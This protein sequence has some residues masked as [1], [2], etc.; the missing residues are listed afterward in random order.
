M[1]E[2]SERELHY[3]NNKILQTI[4]SISCETL[5]GCSTKKFL[6]LKKNEIDYSVLNIVLFQVICRPDPNTSFYT[7]ERALYQF[8][9]TTRSTRP[10]ARIQACLKRCRVEKEAICP[11]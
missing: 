8:M 3:K 6:S 10:H 1:C 11:K 2:Y 7:L 9:M 5:Q 4:K